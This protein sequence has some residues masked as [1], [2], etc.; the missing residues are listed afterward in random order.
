MHVGVPC[1]APMLVSTVPPWH[2]LDSRNGALLG[3]CK[4]NLP[5]MGIMRKSFWSQIGSTPVNDAAAKNFCRTWIA[6]V[7]AYVGRELLVSIPF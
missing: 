1:S 3:S 7:H 6:Q 4:G 2:I 5:A